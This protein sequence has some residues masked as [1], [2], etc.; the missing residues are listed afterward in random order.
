MEATSAA[1]N[2]LNLWRLKYL[3]FYYLF[4]FFSVV[5]QDDKW[6]AKNPER[7]EAAVRA[8]G[9]I[10]HRQCPVKGTTSVK[11]SFNQK[12]HHCCLSR[13]QEGHRTVWTAT[14]YMFSPANPASAGLARDLRKLFASVCWPALQRFSSIFLKDLVSAR[15]VKPVSG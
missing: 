12:H 5:P 1:L 3:I 11:Q 7:K 2:A 10:I 13:P 15:R 4:I 14:Y 8:S 6:S 9:P